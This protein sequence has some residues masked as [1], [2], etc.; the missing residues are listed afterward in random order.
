MYPYFTLL[1][2]VSE[3]R[4]EKDIRHDLG[5]EM[6][7]NDIIYNLQDKVRKPIKSFVIVRL[8][9]Y[10]IKLPVLHRLLPLYFRVCYG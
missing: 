7:K 1:A 2:F 10:L 8:L 9:M 6:L 5:L 4:A 3:A